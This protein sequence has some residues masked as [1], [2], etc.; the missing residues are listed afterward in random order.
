MTTWKG[1]LTASAHRGDFNIRHSPSLVSNESQRDRRSQACA[2]EVRDTKEAGSGFPSNER[3][4]RAEM[5]ASKVDKE[6]V[7]DFRMIL[8]QTAG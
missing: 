3:F 2:K 8:P 4:R 7:G 6:G 1:E 5:T